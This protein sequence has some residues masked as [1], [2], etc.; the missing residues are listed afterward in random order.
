MSTM[1]PCEFDLLAGGVGDAD[2]ADVAFVDVLL[3]GAE[4]VL[5]RRTGVDLVQVVEADGVGVESLQR[6]LDLGVQVLG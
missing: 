5:E 6:L 1:R 4:A 3:D 2:V